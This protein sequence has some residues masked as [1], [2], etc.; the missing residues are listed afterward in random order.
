MISSCPS[1]C[2]PPVL[3]HRSY[4]WQHSVPSMVS[5]VSPGGEVKLCCSPAAY[6]LS[7]YPTAIPFLGPHWKGFQSYCHFLQA[8]DIKKTLLIIGSLRL[9]KTTKV[10]YSNHQPISTM[11][12]KPRHSVLLLLHTL[13][14]WIAIKQL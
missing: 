9:E 1:P 7:S 11:P 6:I 5:I 8:A 14:F 3:E 4:L 2:P 13:D 10:I 12:T